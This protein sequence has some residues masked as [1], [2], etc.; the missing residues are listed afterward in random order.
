MADG[1]VE[2]YK[3]R[4]VAHGFSKQPGIDYNETF[5]P[6]AIHDTIRMV[7][8]VA[9]NNKWYVHQMDVMST[10]LNGSLEEVFY[11]RQPPQYEVDG[12][13]DKVYRLKKALYGLKQ[14]PR[15]WYN[16]IDEYLNGEGFNIIPSEPTLYT[17]VNQEGK[18]L[19]I[20]LYVDDLI[21]IEYLSVDEFKKSMKI[22]FEMIDLGMMKYFLG[23]KVNQSKDVIFIYQTKY[24]ND[25]LKR[26]RTVNCKSPQ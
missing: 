24:A 6:V 9:S 10:F 1:D 18:I 22:E 2:K 13:E 15:V 17:K 3:A 11:V 12:Q 5:A 20:F 8:T 25:V 23:I 4:L 21:F 26:F 14:A 16:R 19:I 7:L